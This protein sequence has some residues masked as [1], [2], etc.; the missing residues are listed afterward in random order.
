MQLVLNVLF[1]SDWHTV[2][3]AMPIIFCCGS[4]FLALV[5]HVR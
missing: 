5:S 3:Y 4:D 2:E 1:E